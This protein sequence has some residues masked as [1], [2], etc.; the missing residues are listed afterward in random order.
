[1]R[2]YVLIFGAIALVASPTQAKTH[3]M[4]AYSGPRYPVML[5]G[6]KYI[7]EVHKSDNTI[8]MQGALGSGT[9]SAD[10]PI[11]VWR[12]VAEQF[13]TPAGCGIPRVEAIM[14]DGGT[15]EA[16][17][18][19]PEGVDFHQLVNEQKAA[20]KRGEPLQ[21]SPASK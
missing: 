10:T 1:M 21:P 3:S 15:W 4:F 17:V 9:G 2:T 16:T 18:M 7:V 5:N 12:R 20:L 11:S 6:G 13:V 19:C 8:L 14:K